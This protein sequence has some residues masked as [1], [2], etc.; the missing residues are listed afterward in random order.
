MSRRLTVTQCRGCCC[1]SVTKHP[2]VDHEA[3]AERIHAAVRASGAGVSRVA[4]CLDECEHSDVVFIRRTHTDH[5]DDRG[6]AQSPVGSESGVDYIWL[7]PVNSE[8]T[9][10]ALTGWLSEGATDPM[11]TILRELQ[12]SKRPPRAPLAQRFA[13]GQETSP[14]C[15][16][17]GPPAKRP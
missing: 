16:V 11:P 8:D 12:F 1:G 2:D 10:A 17:S 3:N 15:P 13:A 4:K 5:H 7:G 9:V 6:A 14:V